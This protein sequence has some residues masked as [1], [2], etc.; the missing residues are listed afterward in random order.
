MKEVNIMQLN[1]YAKD[2]GGVYSL[3]L[4]PFNEDRTI[5]YSVYPEYVKWQVA[6]GAHHLFANSGTSEMAYLTLDE[7]VKLA[8]LTVENTSSDVSVFST[9]NMEP[10]WHAQLEEIK[11]IED[12][13]VKGLVFVTKGYGNDD[14]RM[15]TYMCELAEHTQLP[16]IVYEFPGF[17]NNKMSAAV[18][19][20]LIKTGK[21]HGIKDT[22]C[23]IQGEI[24]IASKLAVQGDSCVMQANIPFLLESYKM[25]ARGVVATPS[26][27]GTKLLR[28]MWDAYCNG[29]MSAAEEYHAAVCSLSDVHNCCFNP[30]VKYIV[31]LAG[32]PMKEYARGNRNPLSNQDKKNLEVWYNNAVRRGYFD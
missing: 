27:C 32:I 7:R 20:K 21:F 12:T 11:R 19:E 14:E 16:I 17:P 23:E 15:Y 28:K 4:T 30:S 26:S 29:D 25:G 10:T 31:S 6:Q 8:R 2:F 3:M 1:D 5:D 24:S 9:A 22:T 18:Y 13:G